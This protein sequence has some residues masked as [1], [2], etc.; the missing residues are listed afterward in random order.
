M[1]KKTL[2]HQSVLALFGLTLFACGGPKQPDWIMKGAGAFKD[3]T[4]T[5]YGVGIAEGIQSE[6]LRRT[7]ADNRAIA[8]VSKQLSVM[9]T[10]L[11]RDYLSNTSIPAEAKG[12]E[13]Q[14]VENTVKTF[15]DNVLS[16][17]TVIDR[18]QDKKTGTLYSL[19][20]LNIDQLKD[21]ADKVQGLSQGVRDHIK[22]NA[23]SAFDKLNAEQEKHSDK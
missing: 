15:T 2:F 14:Y 18:Y 16:G 23:E 6:A 17:V 12:S 4:K 20:T 11:M 7:T 22:A 3:R 5:F 9:S 10:S 8:D 19:A 21:L 13:E 1:S